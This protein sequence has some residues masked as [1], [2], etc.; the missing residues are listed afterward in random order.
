MGV[1]DLTFSF[2]DVVQIGA[3]LLALSS[4]WW[5][6]RNQFQNNTNRIS[7]IESKLDTHGTEMTTAVTNINTKLDGIV[8][9]IADQNIKI[10]QIE[11]RGKVFE[12]KFDAIA[13]PR[14]L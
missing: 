11:A 2:G 14:A 13:G 1:D 3:A 9:S 6:M 4:A 7:S 12:E 8:T 5:Y 10:A